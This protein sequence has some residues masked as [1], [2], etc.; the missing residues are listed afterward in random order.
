MNT[1]CCC[2][3]GTC[4]REH[5]IGMNK[6]AASKTIRP[7]F[8]PYEVQQ[9]MMIRY[10]GLTYSVR[11]KLVKEIMATCTFKFTEPL[12]RGSKTQKTKYRNKKINN[13]ET[14]NV[15]TSQD[16]R[17]IIIKICY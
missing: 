13:F 12:G 16:L 6:D 4:G 17:L 1:K 2:K 7:A 9:K 14:T 10:F 3:L 11:N 15:E 5:V 8:M